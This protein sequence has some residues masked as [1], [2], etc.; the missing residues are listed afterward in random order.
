MNVPESIVFTDFMT[1]A[2]AVFLL[3]CGNNFV[4]PLTASH[5]VP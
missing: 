2:V 1:N 3:R 4:I 5:A